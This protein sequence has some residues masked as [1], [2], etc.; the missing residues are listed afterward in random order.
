MVAPITDVAPRVVR[1]LDFPVDAFFGN[2]IGVVAI[3]R[4]RVHELGDNAFSE[5]GIAERQCFP[6]LKDI[7]PVAFIGQKPVAIFVLEPDRE[8]V[9]WTAGISVAATKCYRQVLAAEAHELRIASLCDDSQQFFRIDRVRQAV[10]QCSIATIYLAVEMLD[11][12]GKVP[13][14]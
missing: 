12:P 11:S 6:V 2:S 4:R 3:D 9:P 13:C 1:F 5:S 10:E 8:L 7:A 14:R